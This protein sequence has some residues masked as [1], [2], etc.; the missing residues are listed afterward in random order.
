MELLLA[1]CQGQ[2]PE[3]HNMVS[4]FLGRKNYASL[5]SGSA[6][7]PI[8]AVSAQLLWCIW[9]GKEWPGLLED[10]NV[11]SIDMGFNTIFAN[12]W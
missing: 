10:K 4:L 3:I 6:Y 5:F 8:H 12:W 9:W 1:L 7:S 2:Y 11:A